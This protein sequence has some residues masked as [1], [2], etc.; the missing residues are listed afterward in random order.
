MKI[1]AFN[2]NQHILNNFR[3]DVRVYVNTQEEKL[4]FLKIQRLI[5]LKKDGKQSWKN[6]GKTNEALGQRKC[7]VAHQDN[8]LLYGRNKITFQMLLRI[9][10]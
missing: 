6:N 9:F 1:S 7:I 4:L 2:D 3:N 10:E 5:P 8:R